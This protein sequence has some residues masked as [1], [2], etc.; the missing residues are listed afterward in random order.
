MF[1][2]NDIIR[3][4]RT[5]CVD[6]E[7]KTVEA[8]K[9]WAIRNLKLVFSRK[10]IYFA[11]L[12]MCAE[13]AQARPQMKRQKCREFIRMTPIDRV[14]KVLGDEAHQAIG[15]YDE[16]LAKLADPTFRDAIANVKSSERSESPDYTDLKNLSHH[17]TWALR[18]AFNRHYD[19]THPIHKA[20]MF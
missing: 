12:I 15:I 1:M 13:L 17:F 2:L 11:G 8:K 7:Y 19:T 20:I 10:L 14:L 9:S 3:F 4:Y 5:M 6:F 18:S 16:F